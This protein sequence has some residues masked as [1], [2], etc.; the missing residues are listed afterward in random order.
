V[1]AAVEPPFNLTNCRTQW[2]DEIKAR[3]AAT[4]AIAREWAV[5]QGLDS[6]ST[7]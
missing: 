5:S 7:P 1:L 6:T 3:R 4:A 2:T